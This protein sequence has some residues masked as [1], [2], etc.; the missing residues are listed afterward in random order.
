MAFASA[1]AAQAVNGTRSRF[2]ALALHLAANVHKG[3]RRAASI[4]KCN[5]FDN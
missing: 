4:L 5:T 3:L 2:A 1:P